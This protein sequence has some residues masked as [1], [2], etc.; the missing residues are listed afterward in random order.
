MCLHF[1]RP[2]VVYAERFLVCGAAVL[3]L[4]RIS[5]LAKILTE[6]AVLTAGYHKK[7]NPLKNTGRHGEI[8]QRGE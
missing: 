4:S 5:E 1:R 3:Y 2:V 8:D 6:T 7:I